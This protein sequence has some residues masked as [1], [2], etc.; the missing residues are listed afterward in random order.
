VEGSIAGVGGAAQQ[1]STWA[2]MSANAEAKPGAVRGVGLCGQHTRRAGNSVPRSFLHR[3]ADARL[4]SADNT[5]T[6][7]LPQ[8]CV[9]A[10]SHV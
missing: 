5:N 4:L 6:P 9:L 7:W 1:V 2:S 8:Q 3:Q 10:L